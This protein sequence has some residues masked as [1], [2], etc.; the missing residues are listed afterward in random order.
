MYI[1]TP[2]DWNL[3]LTIQKWAYN[4]NFTFMYF[5]GLKMTT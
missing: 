4:P 1:V 3:D 5:S 2:K